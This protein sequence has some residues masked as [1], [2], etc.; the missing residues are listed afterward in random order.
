VQNVSAHNVALRE[1]KQIE[2]FHPPIDVPIF[3]QYSSMIAEEIYPMIDDNLNQEPMDQHLYDDQANDDSKQS[4]GGN[5]K[6][7]PTCAWYD[8]PVVQ[9]VSAHNVALRELKQ[10]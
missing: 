5:H 2:G 9:N 7:N 6:P 1:L 8:C 10:I 3:Q 4:D